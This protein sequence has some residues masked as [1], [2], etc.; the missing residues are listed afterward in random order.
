MQQNLIIKKLHAMKK[1]GIL[2]L[3]CSMLF[4]VS[5][6]TNTA[7]NK[8]ADSESAAKETPPQNEKTAAATTTNK[9][10]KVAVAA[11]QQPAAASKAAPQQAVAPK[12]AGAIEWVDIKDLEA[13][14]KEEP[15]KVLVDLYTNW[16][17]WC[18]K[19]DKATFQNKQIADYVNDNFYAVK[20]NAE[21]KET[22]NFKGKDY[23][24]VQSGRRGTNELTYTLANKNRIGYPT[25]AFLDEKLNTIESFPGFKDANGF[26]AIVNYINKEEFK[27]GSLAQFQ[28]KFQSSIPPSPRAK[29]NNRPRVIQK[30]AVQGN[31]RLKIDP[32]KIQRKTKA[33]TK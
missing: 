5:C 7:D 12:K 23:K 8:K 4:G 13:K 24:Y 21:T 17:G 16:C 33:E 1:L 6:S 31:N 29:A 15:K 22:L 3:M 2:I 28:Q 25:I 27:K 19:M 32:S 18:K 26:D 30:N 9:D 20:F 14:M 11:P 10:S